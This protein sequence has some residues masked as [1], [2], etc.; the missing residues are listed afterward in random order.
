MIE[1]R[2]RN[3]ND[4]QRQ[5]DGQRTDEVSR[6]KDG[7]GSQRKVK[8]GQVQCVDRTR[9]DEWIRNRMMIRETERSHKY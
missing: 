7:A 4:T 8:G 6:I 5:T 2:C 1:I 3:D 9:F